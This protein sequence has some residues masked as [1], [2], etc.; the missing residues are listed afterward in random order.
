MADDPDA[1]AA[2]RRLSRPQSTQMWTRYKA[3]R[4]D[5]QGKPCRVGA[6]AVLSCDE[7]DCRAARA[8]R[9]RQALGGD[10]RMTRSRLVR[11]SMRVR[12]A[13]FL[14]R[15]RADRTGHVCVDRERARLPTRC[16]PPD[17]G[18][19]RSSCARRQRQDLGLRVRQRDVRA[20]EIPNARRS[21]RSALPRS[22]CSPR[23]RTL[24]GR[25]T[26]PASSGSARR[27]RRRRPGGANRQ[28]KK[29]AAKAQPPRKSGPQRPGA[30][31]TQRRDAS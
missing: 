24:A 14:V 1:K 31:K 25:T 26:R 12:S 17:R 13:G 23:S 28:A 29:P 6:A 8:R 5:R 18:V 4:D 19:P 16:E 2:P 9:R 30:C 7:P 3:R 21:S 27:R 20:V 15:R 10:G 11:S 22:S